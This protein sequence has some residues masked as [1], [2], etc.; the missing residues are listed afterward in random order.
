MKVYDELNVPGTRGEIKR[1][2][3]KG[4]KCE[5]DDEAM[6]VGECGE[7]M[8]KDEEILSKH[9]WPALRQSFVFML[10]DTIDKLIEQLDGPPSTSM[11]SHATPVMIFDLP[12]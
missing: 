3:E 8:D 10:H 12:L 4:E 7:R 6:S 5:A 1:G 11:R 9:R 2:D